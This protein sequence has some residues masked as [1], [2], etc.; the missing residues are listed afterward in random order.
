MGDFE[1]SAKMGFNDPVDAYRNWVITFV[2]RRRFGGLSEMEDALKID[3]V[4]S[5]IFGK[6]QIIEPDISV[7]TGK[8]EP[9]MDRSTCWLR[10][11]TRPRKYLAATGDLWVWNLKRRTNRP[12][13]SELL[14]TSIQ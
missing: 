3:P 9:D 1:A 2:N 7:A 10:G 12:T 11:R 14:F 8:G 5:V 6:K 13:L 4:V